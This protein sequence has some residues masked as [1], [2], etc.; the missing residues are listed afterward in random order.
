VLKIHQK[1]TLKKWSEAGTILQENEAF[2]DKAI[3]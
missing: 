3:T 2:S 1:V